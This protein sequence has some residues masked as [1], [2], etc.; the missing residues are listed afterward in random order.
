MHIQMTFFCFFLK[1]A[2]ALQNCVSHFS[3]QGV[4]VEKFASCTII[5]Q[6]PWKL[7]AEWLM[8]MLRCVK[9]KG[10]HSGHTGV[11]S[12]LMPMTAQGS[13]DTS[14]TGE[15]S[16]YA[17]PAT[18]KWME[19]KCKEASTSWHQSHYQTRRSIALIQGFAI[20]AARLRSWCLLR[21]AHEHQ[22]MRKSLP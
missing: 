17:T 8:D 20:I 4:S 9:R 10:E 16:L 22:Q 3:A 1:V 2:F 12:S 13:E 11:T 14:T 7:F 15:L 18:P 6:Q 21:S 5:H 19:R